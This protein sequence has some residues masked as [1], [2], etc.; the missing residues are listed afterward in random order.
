MSAIVT[1]DFNPG[2]NLSPHF[3]S[4]VGTN[5]LESKLIIPI[6]HESEN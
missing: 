5:I 3:G 6:D 4:T 1:P 2:P